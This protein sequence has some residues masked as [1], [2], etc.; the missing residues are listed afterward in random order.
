MVEE[1][2]KKILIV[3]DNEDSRELT[4]K[5]LKRFGYQIVEAIDGE[6]ALAK[7]FSEK[8]D[9][10]L[11]DR[12]LPKIDGLEVTRRLKSD[13]KTKH[14][15]ILALTAHAMRGDREKALEAGCEGYISKPI[16]VRKLPEEVKAY[17]EGECGSITSGEKN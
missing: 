7:A 5:V 17:L 13:A 15:T 10:I 4:A 16:D 11:M 8:P 3:D 12:S 6:E 9:L 14:I 1:T 2:R